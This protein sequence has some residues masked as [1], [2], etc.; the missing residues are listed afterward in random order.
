MYADRRT[1]RHDG[2]AKKE[3]TGDV[4]AAFIYQLCRLHAH[5]LL[6]TTFPPANA[7]MRYIGSLLYTVSGFIVARHLLPIYRL[8]QR[9]PALSGS[10]QD[11]TSWQ[12][13]KSGTTCDMVW[14]GCGSSLPRLLFFCL[15]PTLLPRQG[16]AL[17]VQ[18][19]YS[20][21]LIPHN[22]LLTVNTA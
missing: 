20:P 11:T 21:L 22:S 6:P 14:W 2:V 5:L 4:S 18:D 17:L 8:L 12:L 1:G 9:L 7:H 10:W 19:M 16:T 3:R 15:F 13:M